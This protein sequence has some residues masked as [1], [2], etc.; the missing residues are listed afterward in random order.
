MPVFID[1]K[2]YSRESGTSEFYKKK[3][4]AGEEATEGS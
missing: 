1:E 3:I 4:R 2:M